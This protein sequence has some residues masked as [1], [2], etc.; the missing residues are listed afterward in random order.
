MRMP[1]MGTAALS[2]A[3]V[4]PVHESKGPHTNAEKPIKNGLAI[5][6]TVDT[7]LSAIMDRARRETALTPEPYLAAA[8][9]RWEGE[10]LVAFRARPVLPHLAGRL[11]GSAAAA[12]LAALLLLSLLSMSLAIANC[13]GGICEAVYDHS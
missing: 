12:G 2:V 11:A 10:F 6:R 7:S 4:P 5:A 3:P 8:L 1:S 13:S 9:D